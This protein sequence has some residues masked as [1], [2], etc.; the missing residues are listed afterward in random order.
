M[1]KIMSCLALVALAVFTSGAFAQEPAPTQ[2]P[3]PA[4]QPVVAP[5]PAQ[6]PAPAAQPVAA[7]E[8]AQNPAPA[9]QPVIAQD[10][11][12]NPAPAPQPVVAPDP[13]ANPEPTLTSAEVKFDTTTDNK[14]QKTRL[15]V[16]MKTSRGHEIA[17]SEG[18]TGRWKRNSTHTVALEVEGN[19]T[20]DEI[21]DGSVSLTIHP[22]RNDAWNFNYKVTLKFSD[23]TFITRDF[24]ACVLTE[25]DPS[26]TDLM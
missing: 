18:N 20:K 19:R 21:R 10:P 22:Q 12:Q 25:H 14:D 1:K 15:D 8:P 6:N 16:Y 17:K 24:H 3:A 13:A 26:R 5:A 2:N 11:G 23:G 9:G 7:Q 4:S